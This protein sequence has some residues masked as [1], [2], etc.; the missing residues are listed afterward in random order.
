MKE[1]ECESFACVLQPVR[2]TA[3]LL[4]KYLYNI[5]V[6]LYCCLDGIRCS[7]QNEAV[8]ADLNNLIAV[9]IRDKLDIQFSILLTHWANLI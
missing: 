8:T 5:A 6:Y 3:F 2:H 1:G 9:V 7:F 4:Y